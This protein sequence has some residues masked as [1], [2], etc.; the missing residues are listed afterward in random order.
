M[1]ARRRPSVGNDFE[2]ASRELRD[3]TRHIVNPALGTVSFIRRPFPS[4]EVE[5]EVCT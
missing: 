3:A 1:G 2:P 4:M 5:A